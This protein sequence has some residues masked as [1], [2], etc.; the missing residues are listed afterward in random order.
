MID[1]Y[2]AEDIHKF[3]FEVLPS[4]QGA[5]VV[6]PDRLLVIYNIIKKMNQYKDSLKVVEVGVYKGGTA[7][8]MLMAAKE[9]GDNFEL[10]LF[11]TFDGLP[12]HDKKEDLH[13]TGQFDDTSFE[14]VSEF[15][16]D[17]T[18]HEIYKGVFPA[19]CPEDVKGKTFDFVHLD[20]DMYQAYKESL[21]FFHS[22]M[23]T[24]SMML[25]DDY[26]FP[27]CPGAKK[28][29]DEFYADKKQRV[30]QL[31]TNQAIVHY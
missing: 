25:F 26:A 13:V 29:I 30:I 18:T 5:T 15:L 4:V 11:D 24:G 22:R 7:K 19:S 1:Q 27:S 31:A 3:F 21:D 23:N 17:F 28:A 8:L 6:S 12:Y 20:V 10:L 2:E 14:A 9:F 16:E